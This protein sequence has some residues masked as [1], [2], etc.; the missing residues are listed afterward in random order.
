MTEPP[1]ARVELTNAEFAELFRSVSTWGLWGEDD[2]RGALNHL[3]PNRVVAA[4]RLVQDGTTVTL[5]LPMNTKAA[6]DNPEP[7]VHTM[8]M[9]PGGH[10][11]GHGE[12]EFAKDFVGADYHNDGHTHIDAFCHVIYDDSLYNGAPA[13]AVTAQGAA[14]DSIE[15]LANGLVARGVLLDI[16]RLRGVPWLEPGQHV[17]RSDLEA[18]EREQDVSVD[19]GDVL[20]VRTGHTRRLAELGPWPTATAKSGLHPTAMPFVAQRGVSVLGSDGNSDTAPSSTEGVDFPVHVLALNAMG[21]HLLDYLQLEDL[22]FACEKAGRWEFLFVA[23]P[24]RITGGTGSPLNP[25]AIL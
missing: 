12:L 9:I 2:D 14:A 15:V 24:L 7:A 13:G 17:F 11:H 22:L 21:V 19:E 5:S 23:A 25:L 20:L 10:E 16:P 8:T 1:P 3:D 6:D 4:S 18:A